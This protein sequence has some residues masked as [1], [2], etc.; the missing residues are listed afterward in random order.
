M[1]TLY[2]KLFCQTEQ[3]TKVVIYYVALLLV[4]NQCST[5][6]ISKGMIHA[7]YF[8]GN[9]YRSLATHERCS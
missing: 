8:I 9:I 1:I 7:V 5:T 2:T 4:S 6:G 3:I